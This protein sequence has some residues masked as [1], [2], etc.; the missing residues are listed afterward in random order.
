M[1]VLNRA[2]ACPDSSTSTARFL[3][4]I[5]IDDRVLLTEYSLADELLGQVL[6]LPLR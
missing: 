2:S 6:Y 5:V 4:N 1:Y 3:L